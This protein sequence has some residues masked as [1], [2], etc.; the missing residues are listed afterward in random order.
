MRNYRQFIRDQTVF[1]NRIKCWL[2]F[3]GLDIPGELSSDE[4]HWTKKVLFYLKSLPVSD[5]AARTSLDL[6]LKGLDNCR[7]QVLEVTR[8][9]RVL[10]GREHMKSQIELLQSVPGIGKITALLLLTELGNINRF[11]TFDRLCMYVG[12]VP[13]MHQS[14]EKGYVGELTVRGH[15]VL[16]TALVECSW[17]AV[18]DDPA[19]TK[20][21]SDYCNRMKKNK[22]IIKICRKLLSRIRFVLKN[23]KK[24]E[25]SVMQ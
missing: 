14:D 8:A 19:L 21:F 11:V 25:K 15:P 22:A 17:R 6:L 9:L 3:Q 7:Q 1:K 5:P 18:K 20:A 24:Y 16:R 13:T 12:L 10:A 2:Y 23:Q 4:S